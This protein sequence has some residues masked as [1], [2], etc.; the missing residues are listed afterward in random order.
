MLQVNKDPIVEV[1]GCIRL[2][3]LFQLFFWLTKKHYCWGRALGATDMG[4]LQ[5][6]TVFSF[7]QDGQAPSTFERRVW[8][9]FI[10][11]YSC[12][13]SHLAFQFLT[14]N[15]FS[16]SPLPKNAFGTVYP[17][18]RCA[19]MCLVCAQ[20]TI[21]WLLQNKRL[22]RWFR[23]AQESTERPRWLL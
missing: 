13:C 5:T 18:F 10:I 19:V 23:P 16:L 17:L 4:M 2:L 21:V 22:Q 3:S 15:L 12:I 14:L 11:A 9:S 8:V 1:A 6:Q 7:L 20:K